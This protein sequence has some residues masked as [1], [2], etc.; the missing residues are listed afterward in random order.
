[1]NQMKKLMKQAQQMQTRMIEMQK[2][3]E[4]E[5]VEATAGG[6]AIVVRVNGRNELLE[7]KIRKDAI[8]PEDPETLEDLVVTA[9]R[10]AQRRAA[11]RM[12]EEMSKVTGGMDMSGLF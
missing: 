2:R 4:E 8:D 11:E 12:Q 6:G 7:I 5:S 9:V 10:E 1:M 3:L